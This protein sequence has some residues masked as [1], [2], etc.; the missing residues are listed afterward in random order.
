MIRNLRAP[1]GLV[2]SIVLLLFPTYAVSAQK[3]TPGTL[4]KVYLQKVTYQNKVYT[5]TKSGK[6]LIWNKG[7]AVVKPKA[8]PIST[9]QPIV[10]PTDLTP[11]TLAA[12]EDFVR[13]YKSRLS[14]E[15]PNVEFIVEP[16]MDKALEKQIIDNINV[17]AKF[18]AKERPLSVPL[19][20]WIAMSSEFQWIH[21][22]MT[23]A[24]PSEQLEGGWLD[25]K[26]ARAKAEPGFVGGGAAGD[27]KNGVATLFFNTSTRS[28]WGDSF[29]SQVP[30]HEFTHV[31]QRYEL[32]NTMGPMLCWVREGNA[33]F[34]GWMIAGRNS[35]AA[36]RNFWLQAISHIKYDTGISDYESKTAA[37][38][39]NF[40]VE[41][42]SKSTQECDPWINY[43]LGAMAFQY[44]A[45]NY[46]NDKIQDFYLGLR[47]SWNGICN[48][49]VNKGNYPCPSWK[50]TFKKVFGITPEDAY[51]KFGQYIY[52]EIKW[53]KGKQVLWD[54]EALRIAPIPTS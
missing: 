30:A 32:A 21:D 8:S 44:L 19:K 27:D 11:T 53:A 25:A 48:G 47:D 4:C 13:T 46:G 12:Y 16:H 17:S 2:I 50:I 26:L 5:C 15:I 9:P 24:L 34:Y 1:T 41:G 6:K 28:N 23:K 43:I 22:N 36:Y 51:P 37:Y 18:F 20:I 10:Y 42:E 3:V 35:Q 40:F 52:D 49:P 38:W 54:Q 14:D 45:G 29:W 33:N 31:V 7:V 39:T